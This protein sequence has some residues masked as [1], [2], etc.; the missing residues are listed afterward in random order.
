MVLIVTILFGWQW[1]MTP[2]QAQ[3]EE[4]KRVTDSVAVVQRQAD[5][6]KNLTNQVVTNPTVVPDSVR[7]LMI[8][9]EFGALGS[10]A[11]GQITEPTLE[12][13][14]FKIT[15]SSKGGR[16]KN[17]LLK[18]HFK[19]F[20][21]SQRKD[22]KIPLYLFEDV[23]NR[24]EY[25]IPTVTAKGKISTEDLYFIPSVSGNQLVM[26]AAVDG[27]TFIEQKYV[28]GNGFDID[29]EAQL[30]GLGV[31]AN[32]NVQSVQL[33]IENYLDLLEKNDN[34][35]RS[36]SYQRY[37]VSGETSDYLGATGS[38]REELNKKPIT[39]ISHANQFFNTTLVS[40]G[41]GFKSAVLES[42]GYDQ[43]SSDLKKVVSK[44]DIP[45]SGGEGALKMK[46]FI[47]PNDFNLLKSYKVGLEDVVDYGG[48][49]LGTINRWAIRPI[50]DFLQGIF[51][52]A[53]T[54]ILLL[55]LIVKALLYPLS[56][57][58][59]RSQAKTTAL[60]PEI[61][62]LKVKHKDDQQQV[63]VD[64][65]KLYNEFGVNPLGGCLPTLLQM[66]IWMALFRFFPASI[67][68][69]QKGFLWATDLTGFEEFIKLPFSI[70]IYGAHISLF[71]LLW[72]IS[73][74]AFSWYMMK[75]V[76]MSG[77]PAIMKNMQYFT[78]IIFMVMFNSYAAGLSLYM[79]F[80]NFLNIG[81]TIVTKNYVIDHDKIRRELEEYK[82]KPKKQSVFRQKLEEAMK[83]QQEV[84]QQQTKKK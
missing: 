16:I 58:Q 22:S 44:I 63:Q 67:D 10:L 17:V 34:Y 18:Q 62:K 59:L 47:G 14:V 49:I 12:N 72:G 78:P 19:I 11:Q 5:S 24:F 51:G 38:D 56:Y 71:A 46:I 30:K 64:T 79:L 66:P 3:L 70:P 60:K 75:D 15:F 42:E 1:L 33:N 55:T 73:L 43:S 2:S 77:Q 36:Y 23:K 39:W 69:R 84:K 50:F 6:L 37:K 57:K 53:A 54:C 76:D 61:D 13:E 41:A 35:E 81:Q 7:N 20:T 25:I 83:Q 52:N 26:R 27:N 65:M 31:V 9:S 80:S 40:Q 28:I 4:Q 32:P 21:D 68:F 8:S 48:S 45:F 82:K 74:I 29:Y